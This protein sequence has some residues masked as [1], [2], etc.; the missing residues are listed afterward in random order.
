[1][2]SPGYCLLSLDGGGVRGLATLFVLKRIMNLLNHHREE[3]GLA[4]VKPC[5]VFDIMAGTS[6]GGFVT[7]SEPQFILTYHVA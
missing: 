6:T 1:M 3:K 5:H 2:D 4:H 7:Y